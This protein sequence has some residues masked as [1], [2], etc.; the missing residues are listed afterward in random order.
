MKKDFIFVLLFSALLI[1]PAISA[2]QIDMKSNFSQGETLIAQV[3]GNFLEQ[4]QQQNIF[5]YQ[6]HVRVSFIP[7]VQKIEDKFYLYG[8]LLGK[9]EGN[10]SLIIRD[11]SYLQSGQSNDS[12]IIKNFTITDRMADFSISPG[13]LEA[14]GDFSINA[15][16]LG[17]NMITITSFF[18]NST[19]AAES[20]G[21]LSSLFGGSS[22][23]GGKT[24]TQ[25][26]PGQTKP[27][28]FSVSDSYNNQL[29]Y[30]VLETKNTSYEI[31]V[32]ISGNETQEENQ[33][34]LKFKPQHREITLATNSKTLI[35][36]YLYN[37]GTSNLTDISISVSDNIKPYIYISNETIDIDSN[38]SVKIP[39]N[40]SSGANENVTEGNITAAYQNMTFDFV[41]ALNF[42]RNYLPSANETS[43]F[44]TCSELNGQFCSENQTCSTVPINAEDGACCV[45]NCQSPNNSGKIFG[46]TFVA[47]LVLAVVI[48]FIWRFKKAKRP[49]NLLDFTKKK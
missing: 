28:Y 34:V 4:I 20:S 29:V 30:S 47:I 5:L 25:I 45:G 23:G 9:S 14:A 2:V 18:S 33:S 26:S 21:F 12:D 39:V 44:K 15:Q 24:E 19:S 10:Y 31:P 36:L 40:I 43:L 27:V 41:L 17:D 49:F 11:V 32:F 13:F 48:F 22:A 37:S 38:S 46:W 16:N 35:Y 3:S 8:Q 1:L 7:I 42:S 6:G